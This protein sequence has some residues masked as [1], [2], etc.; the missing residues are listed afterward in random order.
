MISTPS[1][2]AWWA[3]AAQRA[4][5]VSC[6]SM[7]SS[8][9]SFGVKAPMRERTAEAAT[10]SGVRARGPECRI[11]RQIFTSGSAAW[12]ASV[13]SRWASASSGVDSRA[14]GPAPAL[15]EMPPVMIMPTPP[16]ARSAK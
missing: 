9:S 3:R 14:P 12:T 13:T 16:R 5:S 6:C 10:A 1:Y 15:G 7:P 8:S 2:P 4:K 11:C